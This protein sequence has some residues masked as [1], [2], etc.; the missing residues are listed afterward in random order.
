MTAQDQAWRRGELAQPPDC[1]G[2]L[3]DGISDILYAAPDCNVGD[4][5]QVGDDVEVHSLLGAWEL[6][7]RLGRLVSWVEETQRFGVRL[8]GEMDDKAVKPKNLR[9]AP[10]PPQASSSSEGS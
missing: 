4:D 8:E 9:R 10:R 5:L 1:S 2:L 3:K 6:N 7:G